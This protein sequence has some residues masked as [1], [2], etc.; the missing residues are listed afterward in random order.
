VK[1]PDQAVVPR[2]AQPNWKWNVAWLFIVKGDTPLGA[3]K[4]TI[5]GDG[6]CG[7]LLMAYVTVLA[8]FH[9]L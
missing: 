2:R 6:A 7:T 3:Q 9:H 4:K 1:A 5:R 8:A